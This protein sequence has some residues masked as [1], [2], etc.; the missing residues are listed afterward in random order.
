MSNINGRNDLKD[1]CDHCRIKVTKE[2]H[3][4]CIGTLP[5]PVMNACCGHGNIS[6]AYVQLD[7]ED[8]IKNPNAKRLEGKKAIKYIQKFKNK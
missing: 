2:G 4:G 8:Y 5:Y 7:H 6:S 3:D 1:K